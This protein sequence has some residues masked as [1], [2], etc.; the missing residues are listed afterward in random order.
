[1]VLLNSLRVRLHLGLEPTLLLCIALRGLSSSINSLVIARA[2]KV[3]TFVLDLNAVLVVSRLPFNY[4]RN[5]LPLVLNSPRFILI[6]ISI[7]Y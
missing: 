7:A 5:R 1:M 4:K 3:P 2:S 6:F